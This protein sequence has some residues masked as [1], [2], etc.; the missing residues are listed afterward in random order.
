MQDRRPVPGDGP[1][2]DN[3]LSAALCGAP[4]KNGGAGGGPGA[5]KLDAAGG[6]GSGQTFFGICGL[7]SDKSG[8]LFLGWKITLY[9]LGQSLGMAPASDCSGKRL[10]RAYPALWSGLFRAGIL[11]GG[12]G[13]EQ[14]RSL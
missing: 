1:F 10:H 7:R 3:R 2:A 11:G 6:A 13:L 12:Y 14:A 8:G 9:W 5:F 4:R